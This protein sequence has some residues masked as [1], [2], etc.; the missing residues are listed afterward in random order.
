[1]LNASKRSMIPR[2]AVQFVALLCISCVSLVTLRAQALPQIQK[3]SL[4]VH[5]QEVTGA[6]KE[7]VVDCGEY[8]IAEFGGRTPYNLA[9]L[10]SSLACA[11]DAAAHNKRF[12]IVVHGM[13]EDSQT[14]YGVLAN[15]TNGWSPTPKGTF[16]FSYDS[17]PCGGPHCQERFETFPWHIQDIVVFVSEQGQYELG[18]QTR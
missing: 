7:S 12:R 17:A 1:M 11:R 14:A 10:Q 5:I 2:K 9:N 13:T 6:P 4:E 15:T 3:K 16:W 8:G 18:R